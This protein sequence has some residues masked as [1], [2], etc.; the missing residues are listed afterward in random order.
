MHLGIKHDFEMNFLHSSGREHLCFLGEVRPR[1]FHLTPAN[2]VSSAELG[3]YHNPFPCHLPTCL[4]GWYFCRR[5][6]PMDSD[7]RPFTWS[8]S[9][10]FAIS[11][12][13]EC[14]RVDLPWSPTVVTKE[15]AVYASYMSSRRFTSDTKVYIN[16]S[17]HLPWSIT[18]HCTLKHKSQILYTEWQSVCMN[19]TLSF[20]DI[21]N[22]HTYFHLGK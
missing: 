4:S 9:S 16:I 6:H 3:M 20:F 2:A 13:D 7:M 17:S 14:S 21:N 22:N 5:G 10:Y 12:S 15:G 8:T 1:F 19:L 18:C 11:W